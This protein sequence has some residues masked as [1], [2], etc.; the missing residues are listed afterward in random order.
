[1]RGIYVFKC[2]CRGKRAIVCRIIGF[3]FSV[4]RSLHWSNQREYWRWSWIRKRTEMMLAISS[5]SSFRATGLMLSGPA[6]L[7]SLRL[8]RSFKTPALLMIMSLICGYS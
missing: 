4:D 3:I 2:F 7:L 6:A 8:A 1:M 5:L